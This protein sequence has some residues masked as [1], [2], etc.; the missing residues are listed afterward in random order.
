MKIIKSKIQFVINQYHS[1][2]APLK[3]SIWFT[4]CSVIEK[5]VS[6]LTTPIFT[7]ILTSEQYGT[8]SI[9]QSWYSII[10]IFATLNLHA[11]VYNNGMTKWPE[12]RSR[13]TSSLQGLSTSLT[14]LL[15]LIYSSNYSF[16]NGVFGLSTFFMLVMF[17][18]L[19][20][21]P[22]FSFWAASQRYD[23]K[24]KKLVIV[25]IFIGI[26]S[27]ILGIIAV[28]ATEYKAEARI[29]AYVIVQVC[30]GI[31]LYI[32]NMY[33][34]RYFFVKKYWKFALT[35]NLPLIPHYL[36]Q[37]ILNQ[38][39]RI[40]IS[41]MVGNSEAAIYSVAYTIS[42]M[43]TIITNAIN[44]TFIP[45]TYKSLQN[46]HYKELRRSTNI[47]LLLVAF[48][49]IVAMALGPEIIRIFAAP[50]YYEARWIV[51]PVAAA[52]FFMFVFPLF[53]NIEFYFEQTKTIMIASCGA[54]IAN[55]I[56]NRVGIQQY[57]YIAAAYTTLICYILLALT[58]Y[59]VYK[60]L[61]KKHDINESLYDV[62]IIF[63]L[64]LTILVIMIGMT[65]VYDVVIVR[66]MIILL[67]VLVV[68]KN[69]R[70]IYMRLRSLKKN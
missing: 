48:C 31:V 53:C 52:L 68:L 41:Q 56:L 12:D 10:T 24:Y 67:I 50:E 21:V 26:A 22:A 33:K 5:G 7:R 58:H 34:G 9:Y 64:S 2:P 15:L 49:C 28:M 55:I 63:I 39:D 69:R 20:F 46:K 25:S 6:L 36:S 61:A 60:Y 17:I 32:Y 16:W 29:L 13:Y 66:Y 47:L 8:Y 38:V 37:T 40:M 1:I 45:Y 35:F 3:A 18:E 27:P 4:I 44:N 54:A 19:I 23:Y 43:F 30:V 65:L 11:G 57:G 14:L 42:M 70:T 62:K 51:P 59:C